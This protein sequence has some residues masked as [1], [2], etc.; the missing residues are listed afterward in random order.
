[1][2]SSPACRRPRSPPAPPISC[3]RW[4]RSHRRCS[5]CAHQSMTEA[6]EPSF[7]ALLQFLQQQRGFDF[8]G[9]KRPSLM[10]RVARRMQ[11][12]ALEGY[13]DYR[14]YLEV[15]PEEF[16]QLFNA[17]LINVT[18]FFRDPPAWDY[19]RQNV[20]PELLAAKA[21]HHA[22]RV[23]SAG[24]ASGQEAYSL[25]I[26]LAEAMGADAFRERVK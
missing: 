8:S 6:D 15:H 12:L 7:A 5:G 26:V 20:V 14:D 24:C 23:W 22:L 17:I 3:S 19:L 11:M 25:A 18:S 10:R 9:Y 13:D 4:T 16:V 2:P 21:P 1:M